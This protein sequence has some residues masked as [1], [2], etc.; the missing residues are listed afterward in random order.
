[1]PFRCYLMMCDKVCLV[2]STVSLSIDIAC[3]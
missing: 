1:M 2:T 3:C